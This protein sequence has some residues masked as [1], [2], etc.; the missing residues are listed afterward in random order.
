MAIGANADDKAV[1]PVRSS[2]SPDSGD[3]P[4]EPM[5]V[6]S[7][8]GSKYRIRA[9]VL[10]A[11]NVLLF[12][13]VG[14]F[15]FWL[16][17]GVF[18]APSAD[19]YRDYF[20]Q[21]FR[22]GEKSVVSLASLLMEPISVQDVPMQIP[23]VGFLMAALISIPILVS[24]LYRFWSS[25]P[26]IA[27]VG[28]VA[29]MPWLAI[30]LLGS[31][32]IASVRPFRSRFRFV[33]ALLALVPAVV[34]LVMAW[35]GSGETIAG[36]V[37]PVD[38]VKFVAPWVLAIVAAAV[39]FA[40][41][42][43]IA[44]MVNYRP[45]AITPLLAIMFGL[46]VALFEFNVG[47]DEL[48]YRLLEALD[49]HHF[50]DVDASRDLERTVA[51]TWARHPL[52]RRSLKAIREIV[53]NQWLFGLAA[54]MSPSRAAL[55][56]HQAEIVD[57]CDWFRKYYPDSRYACCALFIKARALDMRVDS[58][59]F[60]LTN[61][62]RFFDDFPSD[63]SRPTWQLLADNA[64]NSALGDV[65]LL[66]LAQLDARHGQVDRAIGGLERLLARVGRRD[67]R[68]GGA[69]SQ[70]GSLHS[71]LA[72][73]RPE[74]GLNIPVD[75]IALEAHRL[76]G[77]FMANRD[78][79][80]GYDPL[81]GSRRR[82]DPVWYGFMDIVPRQQ[83]Y[84]ENLERLKAAYPNCQIEDN[85]D[86]EIAKATSPVDERID[87]L[88]VLLEVF[89]ERDAVPEA[90]FRLGVA[91]K[92]ANRA[93]DSED[94]FARLFA[95]HGRSIWTREATRYVTWPPAARVSRAGS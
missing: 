49:H 58:D 95:D 4:P 66:R 92:A 61:W 62:I 80:Y 5:D 19:G 83:H 9:S 79:I 35:A 86:L 12:A 55:T 50:A 20:V 59:E 57:R 94:Q 29:V 73:D 38:R 21:T 22:F 75:G 14:C 46:P 26:F 91:Y 28:I 18:F 93:A 87:K 17:S 47:R 10:L 36:K 85:I 34:Y 71:V 63:A 53:A 84:I 7:R 30:T 82:E 33:S 72:R 54:D 40:V 2:V 69:A 6:W 16:R 65:A 37:D 78:P 48:H 44:R 1:Q 77:L 51:E 90:L 76:H 70:E 27:V 64:V 24:I 13:C 23:I 8:S 74:A 52:P 81:S 39:V 68:G 56:E 60:R 15:A 45:G 67:V 32:I 31:C 11:V 25:L 3:A 89:P 41:V 43:S 88:E 42:L